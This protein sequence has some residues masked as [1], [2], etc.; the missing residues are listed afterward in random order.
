M[1]KDV[2]IAGYA[3]RPIISPIRASSRGYGPT[4]WRPRWCAA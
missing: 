1:Q 2:V 3:D 4:S